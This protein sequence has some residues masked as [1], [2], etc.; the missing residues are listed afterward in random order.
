VDRTWTSMG[1]DGSPPPTHPDVVSRP[2]PTRTS[3]H[4][5]TSIMVFSFIFFLSFF[6]VAGA[7]SQWDLRSVQLIVTFHLP[8]SRQ[9][10]ILICP[11]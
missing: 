6:G 1:A 2:G 7:L 9:G 11:L 8:F 4:P 5:P 10:T 3:A